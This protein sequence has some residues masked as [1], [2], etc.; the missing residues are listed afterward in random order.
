MKAGQ[1]LQPEALLSWGA[2]ARDGPLSVKAGQRDPL[3]VKERGVGM[4]GA[5][6]KG[7]LRLG[8][9][10]SQEARGQGQG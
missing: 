1:D 3:E 4:S 2:Q 8:C 5:L 10:L 9:L 7:A 6:L